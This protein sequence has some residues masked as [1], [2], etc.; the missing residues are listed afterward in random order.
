MS[1]KATD[2]WDETEG[3]V[4]EL[5]VPYRVGNLIVTVTEPEEPK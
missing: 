1:D 4:P 3:V 2:Y 5:G